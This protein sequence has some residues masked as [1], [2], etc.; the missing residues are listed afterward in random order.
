M[1]D[2]ETKAPPCAECGSSEH[3]LDACPLRAMIERD[4]RLRR[5][6]EERRGAERP[7]APVGRDLAAVIEATAAM[8][9]ASDEDIHRMEVR[10]RR[11][12]RNERLLASGVAEPGPLRDEDR[13]MLLDETFDPNKHA[14]R[15]VR[16]WLAR[17]TDTVTPDRN[18]L[19]L[20]GERGTGKTLAAAWAI[21]QMGGRY[22]TLEEYLRDY[23][24]W[25]RDRSR[26]DGGKAE[27]SRYDASGL[28]V[29]DELR[30]DLSRDDLDDWLAKLE[31][32]AWHRIVDRRQSRRRQLTIALTN[33]KKGEV[34]PPS[35][36]LGALVDGTYDGR[37][38]D[39]MRRDAYVIGI[40]GKSM[41]G[42]AL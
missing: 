12:E 38:Y 42:G 29:I 8:A 1:A 23:A 27:L 19:V 28:L 2:G 17:A 20:C 10:L 9:T 7:L 16:G 30:G 15:V 6:R 11:Q 37:T 22:V 39:R 35:G 36:F 31:R 32:P 4:A 40:E 26:E 41:R 24:R 13:R 3:V 25:Q 14:M 5:E 34:E 33:A 18:M 21:A